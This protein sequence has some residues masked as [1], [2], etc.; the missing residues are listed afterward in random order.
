VNQDRTGQGKDQIDPKDFLLKDYEIKVSYLSNHF[1]RMW[2]RFNFFVVIESALIG[3]RFIAGDGKLTAEL[4]IVGAVLSLVWYIFGAQD[5]WLVTRYRTQ[6][7]E[8]ATKAADQV[9]GIAQS[10]YHFDTGSTVVRDDVRERP[11]KDYI[12]PAEW[13]YRPLSVTRLA[14][15]FPAFTFLIWVSLFLVLATPKGWPALLAKAL[16]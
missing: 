3:G 2:T 11:Q 4:A 9:G 5:R 10:D 13:R 8:A 6:A 14:A 16:E 12:S 7:E 1:Q 15:V